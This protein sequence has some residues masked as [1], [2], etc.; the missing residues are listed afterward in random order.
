MWRISKGTALAACLALAGCASTYDPTPDIRD[1]SPATQPVMAKDVSDCGKF[2]ADAHA[3]KFDF[4]AAGAAAGAGIGQNLSSAALPGVAAWL[5]P[6][7]G[8]AGGFLETLANWAGLID[9]DS[10]KAIQ[11]CVRQRLDRDHAGIL[12]EAPL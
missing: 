10:P 7:L 8:G 11:Q 5:G 2:A 4:R 9:T 12:V 1:V 6:L 3:R